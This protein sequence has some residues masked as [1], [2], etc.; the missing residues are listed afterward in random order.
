MRRVSAS[1]T[2]VGWALCVLFGSSP[3]AQARPPDA[4]LPDPS[5]ELEL[6]ERTESSGD[7]LSLDEI[8]GSELDRAAAALPK[9]TKPVSLPTA[10]IGAVLTAIDGV[11]EAAHTLAVRL[12]DGLAHVQATIRFASRAKY[13]AA[14]AYRLALPDGAVVHRVALCRGSSCIDA[15]PPG[16]TPAR[17]ARV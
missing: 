6:I 9:Q 15:S 12:E 8:T 16:V 11:R 10:Q 1:W 2:T 5:R 4:G 13:P 14:L 17:D 3:C 7:P